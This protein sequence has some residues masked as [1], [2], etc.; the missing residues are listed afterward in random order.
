VIAKKC[1][2]QAVFVAG[3]RLLRRSNR[4]SRSLS[5]LNIF[6]RSIPRMIMWCRTP[7]ACP[8]SRA[9]AR[10]GEAGGSLNKLILAWANDYQII[11]GL[12][13]VN[14]LFMPVPLF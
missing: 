14:Y 13:Q 11:M 3:S 9:W 5:S 2:G 10:S 4:L 12:C 6:L 8:P 7:G 1:P